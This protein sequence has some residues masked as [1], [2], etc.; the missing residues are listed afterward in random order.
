[1]R[2]NVVAEEEDM[3][4]S[5]SPWPVVKSGSN[6]HPVKTLQYLLR[7][8]GHSVAADGVFGPNT[9]VAVKAFQSGHGLVANGIFDAATWAPLVLPVKKGSRGDAV[10]GVQEEF[11]FRNLSGDPSKGPQVDCI[12]GPVTDSAVRGFQ[13]ALSLDIPS[14]AID[15]IGRARNR[16]PS[17]GLGQSRHVADLRLIFSVTVILITVASA[18][19]LAFCFQFEL[20]AKWKEMQATDSGWTWVRL[21]FTAIADSGA[22]IGA[23]GAVGCGVLAWTYQSGSA[24][25]GMVDLFACEIATLCRVAAVSDMV[26]RYIRLFQ[27][28]PEG[29]LSNERDG[30]MPADGRFNSQEILFPCVRGVGPGSAATGGRRRHECDRLLHVYEGRA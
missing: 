3:A 30:D 14:V 29:A 1:M 27:N 12:F 16:P 11:Q 24:R 9:E 4:G 19:A 22:F 28:G 7:A 17:N 23:I 10:K 5:I 6:A 15:G 8:R 13:H 20:M 26:P 25:L 2:F 21:A 18:V